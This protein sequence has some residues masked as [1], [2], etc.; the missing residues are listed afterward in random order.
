MESGAGRSVRLERVIRADRERVFRAWTD[1]VTRF[2]AAE[3]VAALYPRCVEEPRFTELR[4]VT[5]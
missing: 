2:V 5:A 4:A 1:A 3:F